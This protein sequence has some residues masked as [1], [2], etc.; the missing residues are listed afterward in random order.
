M[1][2]NRVKPGCTVTFMK[3]F[4]S[5][6]SLMVLQKTLNWNKIMFSASIL[7]NLAELVINEVMKSILKKK[8][9]CSLF[10]FITA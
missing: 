2:L 9:Q 6:V 3:Y 10:Q 5:V 1:T 4:A 7:K 8:H